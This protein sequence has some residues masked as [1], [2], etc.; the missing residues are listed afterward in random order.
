MGAEASEARKYQ[1]RRRI[2]YYVIAVLG[3]L[4]FIGYNLELLLLARMSHLT[5]EFEQESFKLEQ[6]R[7][8]GNRATLKALQALSKVAASTREVL[9]LHNQQIDL[10]SETVIALDNRSSHTKDV[11]S[12]LANVIETHTNLTERM[13]SIESAI[14]QDPAKALSVSNLQKD[15]ALLNERMK[16]VKDQ[17]LQSHVD[18]QF[19]VTVIL[20]IA[21]LLVA[22]IAALIPLLRRKAQVEQS[23]RI[24]QP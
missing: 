20:A 15:L 3:L 16:D 1:K 10:L 22:S 19:L 24:V 2:L 9:E 21:G 8:E 14:N 11:K 4:L 12:A 7:L 18:S 13:S 5:F 23:S 6:N 17:R